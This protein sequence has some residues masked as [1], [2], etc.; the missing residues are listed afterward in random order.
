MRQHCVQDSEKAFR[1]KGTSLAPWK[2]SFKNPHDGLLGGIYYVQHA[3]P[4]SNCL[5]E[6]FLHQGIQNVL[7][8]APASLKHFF[9]VVICR[10]VVTPGMTQRWQDWWQRNTRMD[11]L[12]CTCKVF[13]SHRN[14]SHGTFPVEE[15]LKKWVGK[16][17]CLLATSSS[18][19]GHSRGCPI[20]FG[21]V[22]GMAAMHGLPDMN[23]SCPKWPGY[24][25]GECRS[26][27]E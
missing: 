25:T 12:G 20:G 2:G 9:M 23:C 6:Y 14:A 21:H 17:L 15:A 8:Q 11:L 16:T 4:P 24:P 22:A 5:G 7:W 10:L 13:M 27:Q 19:P 1:T 26:W 18:F 3:Q